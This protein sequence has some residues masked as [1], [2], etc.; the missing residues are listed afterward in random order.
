MAT[1][2]QEPFLLFFLLL[3]A[4]FFLLQPAQVDAIYAEKTV[5]LKSYVTTFQKFGFAANG[6]V[7]ITKVGLVPD[8]AWGSIFFYLCTAD[9]WLSL[10]TEGDVKSQCSII[11]N[12]STSVPT[13]NAFV[14]FS[15]LL[16][17]LRYS[18][19]RQLIFRCLVADCCG[20]RAV[21]CSLLKRLAAAE[22]LSRALLRRVLLCGPPLLRR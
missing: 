19:L 15:F 5:Y 11:S 7:S 18:S 22:T 4:L 2:G 16:F 1:S 13:R 6:T 9:Q 14:L 10:Y 12:S 21:P 17:P 8:E 20:L 3:L